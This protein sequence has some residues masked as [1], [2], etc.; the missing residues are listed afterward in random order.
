[1]HAFIHGSQRTTSG[2]FFVSTTWVLGIGLWWSGVASSTLIPWTTSPA[3]TFLGEWTGSLIGNQGLP[4]NWGWLTREPQGSVVSVSPALGLQVHFHQATPWFS[5]ALPPPFFNRWCIPRSSSCSPV[6]LYQ[7]LPFPAL[8]PNFHYCTQHLF[9]AAK[10]QAQGSPYSKLNS[11]S[12]PPLPNTATLPI[13]FQALPVLYLPVAWVKKTLDSSMTSHFQSPHL[14]Y[15]KPL[16]IQNTN[17]YYLYSYNE[18]SPI[19]SFL[20]Y[21]KPTHNHSFVLNSPRV[22]YVTLSKRSSPYGLYFP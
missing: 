20:N 4:I 2:I 12:L 11:L 17:S 21:I 7:H 13:P 15:S 14:T 10:R 6:L 8:A 3:P 16:S 5:T 18:I 1:M 9:L 19:N 22:S